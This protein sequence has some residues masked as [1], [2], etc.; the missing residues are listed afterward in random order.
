MAAPPPPPGYIGDPL[1]PP[2]IPEPPSGWTT[3]QEPSFWGRLEGRQP[4]PLIASKT[5]DQFD[6]LPFRKTGPNPGQYEFDYSAGALG[7]LLRTLTS[8]YD[9]ATGRVPTPYDGSAA[10]APDA[11]SRAAESAWNI[12]PMSPSYR[13]GARFGTVTPLAEDAWLP[14]MRGNLTKPPLT[15]PSAREIKG[16][17]DAGYTAVRGSGL[18]TPSNLIANL[19]TE[20]KRDFGAAFGPE[21]AKGTF[22]RLDMMSDPARSGTSMTDL[23]A[24]RNALSN[25]INKGG[26]DGVAAYQARTKLDQF[27]DNLGQGNTQVAGYGPP[28]MAPE[29]IGPTLQT[30]RGNTR[31]AQSASEISGELTPATTG[32]IE[33]AE[34]RSQPIA[35]QLSKRARAILESNKEIKGFLPDEQKALETIRDGTATSATLKWFG[36]KFGNIDW[37]SA[38]S[39]GSLGGI[40]GTAGG[41]GTQGAGIIGTG[42]LAGGVISKMIANAMAKGQTRVAEELVRSNSPLARSLVDAQHLSYS[43][44]TARD[45]AIMRLLGPGLLDA[46]TE[47][48]PDPRKKLPPGYL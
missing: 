40:L 29:A 18:E 9:V 3:M 25:I 4:G 5:P 38:L 32:F 33:K 6:I 45:A 35:E 15:P 27:L 17:A 28:S 14:S 7:S 37:R 12:S 23:I 39:A 8:P 2:A 42:L 13:A 48:L 44:H 20:I 26:P 30:A 41:G 46:P 19:A 47:E 43:P 1:A 10:S 16:A 34:G 22:S 21:D 31:A 11:V 36:D 24:H